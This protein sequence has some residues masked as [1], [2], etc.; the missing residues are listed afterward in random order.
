[1]ETVE[2]V[3]MVFGCVMLVIAASI[4]VVSFYEFIK[5]IHE[6]ERS[7]IPNIEQFP[8]HRNPPEP[9][10]LKGVTFRNP[11]ISLSDANEIMGKETSIAAAR[12]VELEKEVKEKDEWIERLKRANTRLQDA[13]KI[14]MEEYRE[15]NVRRTIRINDLTN[16]NSQLKAG[17][18]SLASEIDELHEAY[19]SIR[20]TN[21]SFYFQIF[22]D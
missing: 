17:I 7:E 11:L 1:M 2:I 5:I 22:L 8:G 15:G 19:N 9:P 18:A 12:I 21:A 14:T 6:P 16:E 20:D 3:L 13:H 10:N 4:V